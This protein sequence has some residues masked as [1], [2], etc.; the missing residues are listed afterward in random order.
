MLGG[1]QGSGGVVMAAVRYFGLQFE[2]LVVGLW[3]GTEGAGPGEG[4]AWQ[5]DTPE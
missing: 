3:A 1:G 4:G 5:V 2:K